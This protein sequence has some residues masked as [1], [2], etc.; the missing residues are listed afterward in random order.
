M[1][2]IT[3][4]FRR[5]RELQVGFAQDT[6][7]VSLICFRAAVSPYDAFVQTRKYIFSGQTNPTCAREQSLGRILVRIPHL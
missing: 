4:T 3:K 2:I 5:K 6:G 1:H 7:H